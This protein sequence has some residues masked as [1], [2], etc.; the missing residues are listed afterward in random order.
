M[1]GYAAGYEWMHLE[2]LFLFLSWPLSSSV[3]FTT[4]N[5]GDKWV[6]EWGK[7]H[8]LTSEDLLTITSDRGGE[9]CYSYA[10]LH[11]ALQ[12]A[13]AC[14]R[15]SGHYGTSSDHCVQC[16]Q[17]TNHPARAQYLCFLPVYTLHMSM[18]TAADSVIDCWGNCVINISW[19]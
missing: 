18:R 8:R 6:T 14:L 12:S 2:G 17:V 4:T 16:H 3:W 9:G 1:C 13:S 19:D 11:E 10:G 5:R 7:W 15:C